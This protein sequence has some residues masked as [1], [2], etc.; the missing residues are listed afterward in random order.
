MQLFTK[1]KGSPQKKAASMARG[2]EK[3]APP[4]KKRGGSRTAHVEDVMKKR[5]KR[6]WRM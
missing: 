1:T 2:G 3:K 6:M 4:K 5:A